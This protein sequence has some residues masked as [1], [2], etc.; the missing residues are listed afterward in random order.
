LGHV[1]AAIAQNDIMLRSLDEA[2]SEA[3]TKVML[4]KAHG[5]VARPLR[6]LTA[7]LL[8]RFRTNTRKFVRAAS[9]CRRLDPAKAAPDSN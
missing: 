9:D 4:A 2:V 7:P 3:Q 8:M 1:V 6:N 5:F